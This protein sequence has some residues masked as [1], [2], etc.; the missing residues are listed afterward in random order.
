[1][2]IE[3]CLALIQT[4]IEQSIT[5]GG[6]K[7]K[8]SLITS[9]KLIN[10]LHEVVKHSLV[11]LGVN[12]LLIHPPIGRA[13]PEKRIAG[14]LKFKTQDICVFPNNREPRREPITFKGLFATDET[15]PFGENFSEQIL[16]IN[17]RSQ[18]SSI[19][20]NLD[21][22]YERTY[23]EPLNLHRRLPKMVLGE[24]YLISAREL[25]STSV[26]RKIV[27]YKPVTISTAKSIEKY[28]NGF[29]ALNNRSSQTDDPFKYE[30]VALLIADFSQSPVK[31]YNTTAELKHDNLLPM[32][33][34]ATI[35][36]LT[37]PNFER[38]LLAI[39]SQRFGTGIF[40]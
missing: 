31:L 20:K 26:E 40:S 6:I 18:L 35:E 13:K 25:N 19:G 4:D 11:N 36:E 23:A 16:A 32:G 28:I 22:M 9:Q 2:T 10:L 8:K 38:T 12:P 39:H 30:K 37:Y 27:E 14:F 21:T 34:A 17:L 24:V 33:S 3:Q 5:T 29:S 15:E 1:M 7:G